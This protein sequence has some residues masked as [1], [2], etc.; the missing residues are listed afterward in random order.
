MSF[1]LSKKAFV[2][3]FLTNERGDYYLLY[4][5]Q[6]KEGLQAN[7]FDGHDVNKK[8]LPD[9]KYTFHIQTWDKAGNLTE[10]TGPIGIEQGGEP[11]L[12]I[13][14]AKFSPTSIPLGGKVQ[15]R[16]TV[17][18]VGDAFIR[19]DPEDGV[20]P[21]PGTPYTTDQSFASWQS[22][23]KTPLY[24]ERPGTFRVG[25]SWTNAPPPPVPVR[26]SLGKDLAPGEETTVTGEVQVL[27][28]TREMYFSAWVVQEGIGFPGGA[29]AQTVVKISY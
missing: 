24:Y 14:D 11:R 18:N 1:A 3:F 22:E 2:T 27:Q 6:Q 4:A 5:P 15:V 7:L 20:G 9:G 23:D 13:M 8:L 16:I 12:E 17:K 28:R 21:A 29:R 19:S 25:V 10:A 26:W